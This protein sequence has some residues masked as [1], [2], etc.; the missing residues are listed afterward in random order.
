M[1]SAATR[2]ALAVLCAFLVIPAL[3]WGQGAAQPLVI[4]PVDESRLTPLPGNT[5]PLA[6]AE[7]DRG[8]APPDLPMQRMLLVL[9]RSPEQ[10]AALLKLLDDQQDKA[11]PSYHKWLAPEQFGTQFGPSDQDIQAVT[12]WLQGH[13]FQTIQVTKGRTVVEFSGTAAQVQEAFHTSIHK[14]LVNGEEHWANANDPQ[15]PTALAP[16]LAGVATLHNFLKQPQIKVSAT[17]VRAR[18]QKGSEPQITFSD[19]SHALSPADYGKIYNISPLLSQ[20]IAGLGV[21]IAVVGRSN[22]Y[23]GGQDIRDFEAQFDP[24][25]CGSVQIVFNGPDP[26]D[27]GGGEE[28]EATLDNTWAGALAPNAQIDFVLSATTNTT[29]GVDLS[30]VYAIDN[31]VGQIMTES[32]SICEQFLSNAELQSKESLAEQAAAQGITYFVSSGD[33]GAAGCDDPHSPPAEN[34]AGVNALAATPFTVA[35]GGTE[36]NENGHP[37]TYWS[38]NNNSDGSSVL[39]YIPENVWNESGSTLGL[40][41]SGGG[42]STFFGRPS[43]QSGV[44]GIPPGSF[45]EVPDVSLTA[46]GHD[47]Y[48][49]CYEGSCV[50]DNQGFITL[51]II[52]GTSASTP[53]FASIM[54]LV[55]QKANAPQGQANYVFYRLAAAENSTLSQCNASKTPGPPGSNCVFNDVTVGSNSVPGLT[56]FGSTAGYDLATGLGSVNVNNLV[57]SWDTINF[58]A[59]TT[60]LAPASISATHGSA[61]NLDVSVAPNNGTGTP[62]GDVSLRTSLISAPGF[63]DAFPPTQAGFLTL[64]NGSASTPVNDL[65]GGTYTLTAQYGGD[66]VFGASPPSSPINVTIAPESSSTSLSL[67]TVVGGNLVPFAGGTFGGLVL[68]RADVSANSGFGTPTGSVGFADNNNSFGA[69]NL[70]SGGNTITP[71]GYFGF[72]AGQHSLVAKYLADNSFNVSSSSAAKF[73]IT[74][75]STNATLQPVSGVVVAG[76]NVTLTA[77]L[78]SP[79]FAG[80]PSNLCGDLPCEPTSGFPSGG[81]T[82]FAGSTQLGTAALNGN[83]VIANGI[84]GTAILNTSALPLGLNTV[85]AQYAGDGNYA[86]TTSAGITVTVQADFTVSPAS[87]NV[88]ISAPGGSGTVAI[89]V[90]GNPGYNSTINFTSSSCS[91]LPREST[92]SFNPPSLT[93]SGQTTLTVSTTAPRPAT[94]SRLEHWMTGMG[95]AIAGVMLLAISPQRRKFGAMLSLAVCALVLSCVSCGGSSNSGGGGGGGDPGTPPGQYTVTVTAA[96]STGLSHP[97]SFTLTVGP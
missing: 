43:W 53:S 7:F 4:Q 24:L 66:S 44:T 94:L 95:F 71:N 42:T 80:A 40:W 50:P 65:P 57:N 29:D 64:S 75:A 63:V 46:A 28:A 82:F 77:T 30:E 97:L 70:N 56:G 26:G 23:N 88:A 22:L 27:L 62:A 89:T 34:P 12:S 5:H 81:V 9:K 78:T 92:C 54:A 84:M 61:V 69:L 67:F 51:Y 16:V 13:G 87:N 17:R 39:A 2:P 41:S 31:N 8:A 45:R 36:F 96:T 19:G 21:T 1:R 18:V 3:T 6:R 72:T 60:T 74:Q 38:P 68:F 35:V 47:G 14:Y 25:C 48:L 59:T 10:D 91:G 33:A 32:F 11:S 55:D 83:Q 79:A 37:T 90:T 20:G 73:T 85:F 52:S 76:N 49:L 58:R 93:G 86:P 15:I